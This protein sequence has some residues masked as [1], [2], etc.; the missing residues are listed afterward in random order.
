MYLWKNAPVTA[1]ITILLAV[2]LY[3]HPQPAPPETQTPETVSTTSPAEVSIPSVPFYS[4]FADIRSPEWQKNGCGVT[5]LAMVI[6]YYKPKAAS[7]ETLLAEGIAADAYIQNVGWTYKGLISISAKYG[8]GGDSYDFAGLSAEAAFAKF[9]SYLTDGP[10]IVSVHYKFDP[11]STIPHLVVISGLKDNVLYY[12]D[13]AATVG[14]KTIS[15]AD[16]LRGWKKR[17][18][19]IRPKSDNAGVALVSH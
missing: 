5:S 17:F 7:V 4:Q 19:V 3:A 2:V 10:I 14:G 12:N 16:F 1:L 11:A 6:D 15:V 8:F 13:P 9:K 18:I